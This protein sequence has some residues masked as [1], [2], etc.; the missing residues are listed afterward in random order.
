MGNIILVRWTATGYVDQI[1]KSRCRWQSNEGIII[2]ISNDILKCLLVSIS[3]LKKSKYIIR[4]DNVT[5]NYVTLSCIEKVDN[6]K[7]KL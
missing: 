5:G 3:C 2:F 7:N 6:L 1:S 4:L